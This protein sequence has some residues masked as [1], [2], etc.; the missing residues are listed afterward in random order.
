MAAGTKRPREPKEEAPPAP[1]PK[2]QKTAA[3]DVMD[4]EPLWAEE[5]DF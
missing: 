2:A 1:E 4:S 5:E 3:L